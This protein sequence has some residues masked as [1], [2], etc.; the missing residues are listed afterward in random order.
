MNGQTDMQTSKTKLLVALIWIS[1]NFCTIDRCGIG[2][3]IKIE[4]A[5]YGRQTKDIC[6]KPN[7]PS[8]F[9]IKIDGINI[10]N[11]KSNKLCPDNKEASL[12]TTG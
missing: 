2:E 1:F 4:A 10:N 3:R 8:F 11:L 6:K 12:D 9:N 7:F 5:E